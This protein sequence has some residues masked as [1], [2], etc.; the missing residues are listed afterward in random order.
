MTANTIKVPTNA[1]AE[2]V[3][4]LRGVNSD[5]DEQMRIL[6]QSQMTNS[7]LIGLLSE[8]ATW[9]EIPD[10]SLEGEAEPEPE[11]VPDVDPETLVESW[12]VQGYDKLHLEEEGS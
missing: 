9:E 5:I 7:E 11:P 2:E 3:R 8:R 10:P 4:R 6:R 1:A 12:P